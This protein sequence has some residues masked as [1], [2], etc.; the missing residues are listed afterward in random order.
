MRPNSRAAALLVVLM[1][2]IL[3]TILAVVGTNFT[4]ASYS[5]TSHNLNGIRAF[6]FA[7]AGL[8]W[9]IYRI[10]SGAV[11][12]PLAEPYTET[13]TFVTDQPA[14]AITINTPSPPDFEVT[15]DCTFGPSGYGTRKRISAA[16][17][18]AGE[19]ITWRMMG[20]TE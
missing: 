8:Q 16:V 17:S 18:S 2:I 3:V 7:E 19:L 14:I 11:T 4:M 5:L 12:S 10:K 9:A 15:T 13:W 1:V 20:D 6:Y